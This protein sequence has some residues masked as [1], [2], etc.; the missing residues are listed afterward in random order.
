LGGNHKAENYRVM[1]DLVQSYKA[2]GC[3]VPLYVHFLDSR[4]DYST[5]H[6]ETVSDEHGE[7]VH[8]DTSTMEQR[9]QGQWKTQY[10]DRLFLDT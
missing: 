7:P 5:E 4:L 2:V 3:T 10:F 8:Q 1:V 6:L 9:Y